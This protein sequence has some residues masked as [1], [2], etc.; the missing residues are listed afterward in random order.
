MLHPCAVVATVKCNAEP[1]RY[2]IRRHSLVFKTLGSAPP[3]SS[4]LIYISP[5]L[6]RCHHQRRRSVNHPL[7][8]HPLR[9]PTAQQQRSTYQQWKRI[10]ELL[11]GSP[12][13]SRDF[14]DRSRSHPRLTISVTRHFDISSYDLRSDNQLHS[15]LPCVPQSVPAVPSHYHNMHLHHHNIP[16]RTMNLTVRPCSA[17]LLSQ[18]HITRHS[19]HIHTSTA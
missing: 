10:R 9:A 14:V 7:H 2:D 5:S 16:L 17:I 8:S 3:S 19:P 12:K 4:T 15:K 1:T 11:Q 6:P 18:H 13:A